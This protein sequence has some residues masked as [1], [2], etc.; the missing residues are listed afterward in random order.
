MREAAE[1]HNHRKGVA[2]GLLLISVPVAVSL[3]FFTPVGD[4]VIYMALV[5]PILTL[6]LLYPFTGVMALI[7][8]LAV[9]TFIGGLFPEGLPGFTYFGILVTFSW[10]IDVLVTRRHL[11]LVQPVWLLSAVFV[12]FSAISGL[13]APSLADWQHRLQILVSILMLQ[14]MVANLINSKKRLEIAIVILITTFTLN[15]FAGIFQQLSGSTERSIGLTWDPNVFAAEL[16]T[17]FP[18][19]YFSF[20]AQTKPTLKI[21]SAISA[22]MIVIAILFSESRGILI[23]LVALLPLLF[24]GTRRHAGITAIFLVVTIVVGVIALPATFEDRILESLEGADRGGAGRYDIWGIGWEMWQ[25]YP[26]LGVGSGNFVE[27]FRSF[28]FKTPSA[29]IALGSGISP[30]NIFLNVLAETGL[31]GFSI[32]LIMVLAMIR[33]LK[34]TL[35]IWHNLHRVQEYYMTMA[36]G[37]AVMAYFFA[38]ITVMNEYQKLLWVLIGLVIAMSNLA[39]RAAADTEKTD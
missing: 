25:S 21:A 32:F 27:E 8:S 10:I 13:W 37:Y 11:D 38:G 1:L 19:A 20:Y 16:L 31:V 22:L 4:R 30:H 39:Q 23:G 28:L 35:T 14:L 5:G 36:I 7:G 29:H 2:F 3:Y 33:K 12:A 6:I 17:V 26:I 15:A 18:F 9:S 34:K 24:L